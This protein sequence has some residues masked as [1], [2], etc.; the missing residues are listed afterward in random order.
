MAYTT[1]DRYIET[2]IACADPVQLVTML[3]RGAL[4]SVSA[5]RRYLASGA[6]RERSR[7]ILKAWEILNELTRSLDHTQGGDLSRKLAEL[8]AYMQERLIE[9]NV[10]QAAAPLAEVE[11]LLS[12]LNEA[13]RG[14]QA[15]AKV[16]ERPA[17][18]EPVSCAY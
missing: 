4:E 13:W 16:P 15:A 8:Y 14:I 11:T 12:T 10:H 7:N 3:Y 2:E 1:Y 9:A 17:P 18:H 6:I 5:A